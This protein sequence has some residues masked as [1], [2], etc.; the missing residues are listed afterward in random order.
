MSDRTPT[1]RATHHEDDP[2][3]VP[4]RINGEAEQALVPVDTLLTA[5]QALGERL[6]ELAI[7]VGTLRERTSHQAT[8]I[9][10]LRGERA[11]LRVEVERLQ[12]EGDAPTEQPA[13]EQPR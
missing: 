12:A 6:S 1:Q 8:E 9:A 7:E 4:Y 10:E 5:T 3:N 13:A 2:I 11:Q